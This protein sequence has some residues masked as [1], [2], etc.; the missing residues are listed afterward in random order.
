MAN[1]E[2]NIG[3]KF[4][5]YRLLILNNY[6][7]TGVRQFLKKKGII[8]DNRFDDVVVIS[9]PKSGRT[10]LRVM[11]D[12]LD[13]EIKYEHDAA[14]VLYDANNDFNKSDIDVRKYSDKRVIYLIRDPRDV[15]V[16]SYFQAVNRQQIFNGTLSDFIRDEKFGIRKILL[17]QSEWLKNK[18]IPADFMLLKY[19]SMYEQPERE[20]RKA[21]DFLNARN[22]SDKK[23]RNTV[24]LFA[25]KNMQQFEKC[26]LFRMRYGRRLKPISAD[27]TES[28][29]VRKG[30]IH[31]FRD[32]MPDKD[33]EYCNECIKELDTGVY[34]QEI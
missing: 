14:K 17:F 1:S 23:I 29:K 19:E 15:V 5:K 11:L 3:S 21:L 24:E 2:D 10:W 26:G 31:G 27:N 28:Y 13:I 30:K 7:R 6:F 33:I 16:S 18:D 22:I 4:F 32:Y 12:F 8:K 25:F 9:Y 34:S 20:F